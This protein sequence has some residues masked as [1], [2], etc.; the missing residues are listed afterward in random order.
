[1][2]SSISD[3]QEIEPAFRDHRQEQIEELERLR[4][5]RDLIRRAP[6]FHNEPWGS[7][8][9]FRGSEARIR[10]L[11]GGNR[12]GK[13][14]E[15]IIEDTSYCLGFRPDGSKK[16]LPVPPVKLG[17]FVND[18]AKIATTIMP[19][20]REYIPNDWIKKIRNGHDGLP[21][22]ITWENDSE[23]WLQSYA[24]DVKGQEGI[25]WDGAHFD[26]PP[27][28]GYWIAVR[29][30]LIDRGGRAWFTLTPLGC[31]WLYNDIYKKADGHNIAVFEMDM[32]ENPHLDPKEIQ[33]FIDDLHPDEFESRVLGKF[34]HLQGVIFPEFRRS[35]H[36]IPAHTPP[37]DCPIFMVMDPH[38]RRPSYMIWCYVDPRGR[39]VVF[40]EWPNE[41]FE[42]MKT[43]RLSIRDNAKII[44]DKEAR[45]RN[46]PHERLID[47]NFGRTPSHLSGTTLIEEYTEFDLD[48]FGDINNDIALGHTRIHE[49][50]ACDGRDPMLM[51]TENCRNMVWAFEAYSWKMVDLERTTSRE[52]PSDIGK[53]QM[54]VLR[55][56]FDYRPT[57]DM[58]NEMLNETD[59]FTPEDYGEGYG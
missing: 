3:Q 35:T 54:D 5:K 4:L 19:K 49:A 37:D 36:V 20:I 11:L 57:Y 41:A 43:S 33:A 9:G 39:I 44:W 8:R 38:D 59:N 51:V 34:S 32:R 2:S 13:S 14:T 56:L 17:V 45:L 12:S 10:I 40:D 26:E 31:Q 50:L 42:H 48:F 53:D 55:Y 30:G 16:G 23:M 28:R 52:R 27:P 47:P 18:R 24:Q 15:G 29:R 1:M 7:Q 6:Y 25:D 22:V 46:N 58:G 21:E